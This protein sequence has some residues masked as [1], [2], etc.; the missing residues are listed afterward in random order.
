MPNR[1]S[2][3]DLN[4]CVTMNEI[5]KYAPNNLKQGQLEAVASFHSHTE[6]GEYEKGSVFPPILRV[7]EVIKGRDHRSGGTP[8]LPALMTQ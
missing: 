7:L 5:K 8:R 2:G 3:N 4:I 6:I 1:S